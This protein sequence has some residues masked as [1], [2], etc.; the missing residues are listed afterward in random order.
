VLSK[1]PSDVRVSGLLNSV[2]SVRVGLGREERVVG[3][4]VQQR[5][6]LDD[7]VD[8]V[9]DGRSSRVGNRVEVHRND[10]DSVRELL[11]VFPGRAVEEGLSRQSEFVSKSD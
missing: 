8:R 1:D 2:I 5:G 6:L 9:L 3:E 11:D 4:T 7:L 10:G